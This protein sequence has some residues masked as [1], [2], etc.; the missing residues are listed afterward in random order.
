MQKM[1]A[2]VWREFLRIRISSASDS[3]AIQGD[4]V[5]GCRAA[6]E[7]KNQSHFDGRRTIATHEDT[8]AFVARLAWGIT[9]GPVIRMP[10]L[11][12]VGRASVRLT[13]HRRMRVMAATPGKRVCQHD[14]RQR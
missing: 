10:M 9:F 6:I 2:R 11:V 1:N 5:R 12:L 8:T 13:Q 14:D 4:F 3:Q 7:C